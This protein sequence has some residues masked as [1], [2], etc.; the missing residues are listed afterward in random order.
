MKKY[1]TIRMKNK[2]QTNSIKQKINK[3][4]QKTKQ[5]R[6]MK[7]CVVK[8]KQQLKNKKHKLNQSQ[9]IKVEYKMI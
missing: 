5:Y 4:M 7:I 1:K 9:T 6:N 8:M 3:Y 2:I